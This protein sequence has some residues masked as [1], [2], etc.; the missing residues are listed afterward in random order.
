MEFAL[1]LPIMLLFFVGIIDFGGLFYL[2]SEMTNAARMAVRG[3]SVG[4]ITE[5]EAVQ[6]VQ[7][8]LGS[9]P[10]TFTASTR[11]PDPGDP[12]DTRVSV[13]VSV[14]MSEAVLIDMPLVDGA[15]FDRTIV[16][17]VSARQE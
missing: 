4:E 9:W 8:N 10:A 17:E 2:K 11:M 3:L 15:V 5:A 1:G 7:D 16:T 6:M 12:S 13:T 14:P